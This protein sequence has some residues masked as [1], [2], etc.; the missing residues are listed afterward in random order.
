[1]KNSEMKG[2]KELSSEELK[3][4]EGGSWFGK[5]LWWI[6]PVVTAIGMSV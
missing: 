6:I 5:N 4:I 2:F 1:M 3:A